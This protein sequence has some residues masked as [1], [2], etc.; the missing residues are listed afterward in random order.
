MILIPKVSGSRFTVHGSKVV[1]FRYKRFAFPDKVL[2]SQ[3]TILKLQTI[4][5]LQIPMTK[6]FQ[7]LIGYLDIILSVLNFEFRSLRF[8]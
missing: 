6:T 7:S 1:R 8:V 4:S 2:K 3:I 5:K